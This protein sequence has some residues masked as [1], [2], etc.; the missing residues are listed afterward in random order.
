MNTAEILEDVRIF[1]GWTFQDLS[2]KLEKYE[3]E[4]LKK[5]HEGKPFPEVAEDLNEIYTRGLAGKA[6]DFVYGKRFSGRTRNALIDVFLN[7]V[8]RRN[9][10]LEDVKVL[11]E[12]VSTVRIIEAAHR[13]QS[14]VDDVSVWEEFLEKVL[15]E[16]SVSDQGKLF[17]DDFSD[18][19]ILPSFLT[20]KSGESVSKSSLMLTQAN[21]KSHK[22]T[23]VEGETMV[24]C[25]RCLERQ[26]WHLSL[27]CI[28]CG[29]FDIFGLS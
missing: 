22:P 24:Q 26:P 23:A 28:H 16:L 29:Y 25:Y 15:L 13:Q 9:I 27:N 19:D 7:S 10:S 3:P 14:T 12:K 1:L 8:H 2:L 18:E 11:V 4:F 5:V 20:V 17:E 21:L 6:V